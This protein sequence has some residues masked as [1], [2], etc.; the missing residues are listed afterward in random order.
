MTDQ[1]PTDQ[2]SGALSDE[3]KIQVIEQYL[4]MLMTDIPAHLCELVRQLRSAVIVVEETVQ[5]TAEHTKRIP[6]DLERM[7]DQLEYAKKVL[8][9]LCDEANKAQLIGPVI[10]A[11]HGNLA[12]A[13]DSCSTEAAS[14][15]V[16]DRASRGARNESSSG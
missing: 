1:Q 3:V 11:L 7:Q 16:D 13:V 4:S 6:D 15:P 9:R 8:F 12:V 5:M 14:Q 2:Y 10:N